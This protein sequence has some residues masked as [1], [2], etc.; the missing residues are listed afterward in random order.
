[1]RF[2]MLGSVMTKDKA[3]LDRILDESDAAVRAEISRLE[4]ERT[5]VT[6][7]LDDRI[8][9]LRSVLPV[10]ETLSLLNAPPAP[11]TPM[12]RAPVYAPVNGARPRGEIQAKIYE[13]IMANPK[14]GYREIV[15]AVYGEYTELNYNSTRN[16]IA[17]M[18]KNDWI[19]GERGEWFIGK[20]EGTT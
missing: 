9:K 20:G 13:H 3:G 1:M 4:A 18:K 10:G 2:A 5:R 14:A 16:A 8:G 15:V 17:S 11:S 7:R 6:A 12:T 19:S